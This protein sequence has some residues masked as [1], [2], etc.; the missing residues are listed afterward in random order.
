MNQTNQASLDELNPFEG[1][2]IFLPAMPFDQ[3]SVGD[4]SREGID[5]GRFILY[6]SGRI[7]IY[8]HD[9]NSTLGILTFIDEERLDNFLDPLR[10]KVAKF[11]R[12]DHYSPKIVKTLA[13]QLS[14][15]LWGLVEKGQGIVAGHR[16]TL[17]ADAHRPIIL[18]F[19][20]LE[21][22]E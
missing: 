1:E 21:I 13:N 9:P 6:R 2:A 4:G 8:H 20:I 3:P 11:A 18:E 17:Y 5:F 14:H 19:D 10:Y 12:W 7:F 16:V 22:Q 15:Y